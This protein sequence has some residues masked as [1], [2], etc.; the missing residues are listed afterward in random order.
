[1]D[2]LEIRDELSVEGGRGENALDLRRHDDCA[3]GT[4]DPKQAIG[5]DRPKI[6]AHIGMYRKSALHRETLPDK[7]GV[8]RA[9]RCVGKTDHRDA[10][11]EEQRG[12]CDGQKFPPRERS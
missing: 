11:L 7:V 8:L 6:G 9:C 3:V 1:M 4:C 12:R 2:R 5:S 10:G